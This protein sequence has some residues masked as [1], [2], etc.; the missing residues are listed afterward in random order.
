MIEGYLRIFTEGRAEIYSAGTEAHGLNEY[1]VRAMAEDGADIS[2]Q[3]SNV[4]DE[5]ADMKFDLIIAVCE[6]ARKRCNGLPNAGNMIYREFPDP[7]DAYGNEEYIMNV[8][9]DSRN[10]IREFCRTLADEI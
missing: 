7:A 5:Y 4:I 1:A 2:R 3:T 9:R 10:D 6:S 8:Y